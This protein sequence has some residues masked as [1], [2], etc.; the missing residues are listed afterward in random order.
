MIA[1]AARIKR[2]LAWRYELPLENADSD[3]LVRVVGDVP[4]GEHA[5][6][7]G[8]RGDTFLVKI[9]GGTLNGISPCRVT[10][11]TDDGDA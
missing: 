6:P 3:L 1:D 4:D 2:Y 7:L 9:K 11:A 5:I 8:P 10:V